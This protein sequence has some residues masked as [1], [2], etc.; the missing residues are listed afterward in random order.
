[1]TLFP[2]PLVGGLMHLTYHNPDR[3]TSG[4]SAV[5]NDHLYREKVAELLGLLE[6]DHVPP[7]VKLAVPSLSKCHNKLFVMVSKPSPALRADYLEPGIYPSDLLCKLV[8]AI[9]ALEWPQVLVLIHEATSS[10]LPMPIAA[11]IAEIEVTGEMIEAGVNT[12]DEMTPRGVNVGSNVVEA[13]YRAMEA[14][15]LATLRRNAR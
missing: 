3:H 8:E 5:L 1:M 13:V 2:L 10:D 15:R 6:G 7:R 12:I 11:E 4:V 9:R 14:A